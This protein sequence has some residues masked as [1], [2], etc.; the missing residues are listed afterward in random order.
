MYGLER[1]LTSPGS[2]VVCRCGRQGTAKFEFK[3]PGVHLVVRG[4]PSAK[5][6]CKRRVEVIVS[7]YHGANA[8]R[9]DLVHGFILVYS[10]KRK[11]SLATLRAFSANIPNLPI[12]R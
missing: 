10:T 5:N 12:Q 4:H 1:D 3:L 11:A 6:D 2:C 7:S 9:E 8:F